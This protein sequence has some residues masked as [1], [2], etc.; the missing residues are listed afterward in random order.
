MFFLIHSVCLLSPVL[1]LFILVRR[2]LSMPFSPF[3]LTLLQ[4]FVEC[5]A[6]SA[7]LILLHLLFLATLESVN[8]NYILSAPLTMGQGHSFV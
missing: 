6:Q 3:K 8:T 5:G 7:P 4:A 1:P 2:S